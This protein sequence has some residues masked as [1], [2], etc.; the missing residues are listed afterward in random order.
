MTAA[1][2][3]A[4]FSRVTGGYETVALNILG[5]LLWLDVERE[6]LGLFSGTTRS[7]KIAGVL[8]NIT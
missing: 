1:R 3:C 4:A 6:E 5:S 7:A 8:S 2:I